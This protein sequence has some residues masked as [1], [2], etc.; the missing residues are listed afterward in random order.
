MKPKTYKQ[1]F[2]LW[3]KKL[4]KAEFEYK[5]EMTEDNFKFFIENKIDE[6]FDWME[7]E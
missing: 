6:M 7:M 3:K 5:E 4:I 1:L 2:S